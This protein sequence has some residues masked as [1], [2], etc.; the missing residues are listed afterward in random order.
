MALHVA[1]LQHSRYHQFV[2]THSEGFSYFVTSIA[3]PAASGWS[4]WPGGTCTHWKSA[5]LS[6]AHTPQRD[7]AV[8]TD[9]LGL[10][11]PERFA[12]ASSD[13]SSTIASQAIVR[14]V[15]C[16][17]ELP[18]IR[19]RKRLYTGS[20]SH[21]GFAGPAALEFAAIAGWAKCSMFCDAPK[22]KNLVSV[23]RRKVKRRM[24]RA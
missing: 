14:A 20:E 16:K 18:I 12:K 19:S 21:I 22:S 17:A 15:F 10:G 13:R 3:A 7:V 9:L 4:D 2:D 11:V 1:R 8:E 24:S 5:A 23:S 6:T